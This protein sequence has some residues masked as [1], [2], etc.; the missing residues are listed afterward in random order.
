[1]LNNPNRRRVRQIDPHVPVM[2]RKYANN[3]LVIL[4]SA[5][6]VASVILT[7]T[8]FASVKN[9]QFGTDVMAKEYSQFL[10]LLSEQPWLR[11]TS[12]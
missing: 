11:L 10:L 5:L 9:V 12:G 6:S 3:M 4:I 1:M 8:L 2:Y 7:H